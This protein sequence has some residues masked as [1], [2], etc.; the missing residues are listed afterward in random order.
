MALI[1][2]SHAPSTRGRNRVRHER[3]VEIDSGFIPN[4]PRASALTLQARAARPHSCASGLT[5]SPAAP[6]NMRRANKRLLPLLLLALAA[7]HAWAASQPQQQVGLVAAPRHG[8]VPAQGAAGAGGRSLLDGEC[9]VG[10]GA[11]VGGGGCRGDDGS[12]QTRQGLAEAN[13][14]PSDGR[15]CAYVPDRPIASP[16]PPYADGDDKGRSERRSE[17]ED[18][19]GDNAVQARRPVPT[20]AA[21]SQEKLDT[22]AAAAGSS[23]AA[24]AG[25][26]FGLRG[27]ALLCTNAVESAPTHVQSCPSCPPAALLPQWCALSAAAASSVA[28][29]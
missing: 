21:V 28:R 14:L 13:R 11:V 6:P 16:P 26:L 12:A 27:S 24:P 1:M 25:E 23:V 8:A 15:R 9:A 2:P 17:R 4:S 3:R 18:E 19:Q 20:P 29:A 5:T 22:T 7:T 10:Q